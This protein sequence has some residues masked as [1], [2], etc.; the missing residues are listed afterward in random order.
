L[1]WGVTQTAIEQVLGGPKPAPSTVIWEYYSVKAQEF[2][3]AKSALQA[4]ADQVK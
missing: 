2:S 3:S 4:L 1:D